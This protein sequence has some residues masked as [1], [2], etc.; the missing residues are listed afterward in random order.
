M[1]PPPFAADW[2][3]NHMELEPSDRERIERAYYPAGHMMYVHEESREALD[4][5]LGA[6]YDRAIG[7]DSRPDRRSAD[8]VFVGDSKKR[9]RSMG[10]APSSASVGVSPR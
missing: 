6:F 4:R 1:A 3:F 7:T 9:G 2:V 8:G 5:D 10:P